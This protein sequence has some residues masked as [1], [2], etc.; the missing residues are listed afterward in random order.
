MGRFDDALNAYQANNN[1]NA[2][3]CLG[4]NYGSNN[5]TAP[6]LCWVRKPNL[7]MGIGINLEQQLS[8]NIGVFF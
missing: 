1:L 2:T 6:D 5:S 7:K 4:F 3:N 8:D